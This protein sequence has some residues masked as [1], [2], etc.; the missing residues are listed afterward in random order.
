MEILL[1]TLIIIINMMIQSTILP[2]WTI[3]GYAPNTGLVLVVSIALFKGQYYGGIFGLTL[4][5]LQDVLFSK[6]IGINGLIY[7][8]IGFSVGS[9]RDK[10]NLNNILVPSIFTGAFTV[11]YNFLYFFLILFL[12]RNIDIS[13]VVKRI[14][15]IE[16][17]YNAILA[18]FVNKILKKYFREPSLDFRRHQ[19]W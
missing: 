17:I 18:V 4:G 13:L 15:S 12:S 11:F 2:Y 16:I 19:R 3:F 10:F 1:S 8:L 14:F 5:L 6:V 9:L 7:F